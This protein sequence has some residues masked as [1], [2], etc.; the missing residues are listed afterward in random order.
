MKQKPKRRK[1]KYTTATKKVT[2]VFNCRPRIKQIKRKSN[3][4]I[5]YAYRTHTAITENAKHRE[6]I[7]YS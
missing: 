2:D 1:R 5:K 6:G 7:F 3:K 4:R